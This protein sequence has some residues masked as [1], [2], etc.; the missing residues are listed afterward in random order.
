MSDHDFVK[1]VL[2]F[3][4]Q[5][6]KHS[7]NPYLYQFSYKGV[8]GF[9]RNQSET[10]H[11]GDLTFD[12]QLISKTLVAEAIHNAKANSV[13][14]TLINLNNDFDKETNKENAL[15]Y[16]SNGDIKVVADRSGDLYYAREGEAQNKS[17]FISTMN[18]KNVKLWHR[19]LGHLNFQ[20]LNSSLKKGR[21]GGLFFLLL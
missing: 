3:A 21:L 4:E 7:Q 6:V 16:D 11:R 14:K 12:K 9:H 1:S 8:L 5:L 20:D 15:I 18:S 19:R 13:C 17:A 2:K 10:M